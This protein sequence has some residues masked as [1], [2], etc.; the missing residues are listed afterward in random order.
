MRFATQSEVSSLANVEAAVTPGRLAAGIEPYLPQATTEQKG[1]VELATGDEV[2]S[3]TDSTKAVT[4]A[5]LS[6]AT[7]A[8][9]NPIGTIIAF[10][11]ASA[12][13]GYLKCNGDVIN[14]VP[15]QTIQGVTADF[16]N[17]R[18]VLGT[19]YN[20]TQSGDVVLPDLRGEFLRGW[21]DDRI[22][23]DSGR[24]MGST[25]GQTVQS[26]AHSG[27]AGPADVDNAGARYGGGNRTGETGVYSTNATGDTETR[28]RNVAILY[29]IKF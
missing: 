10:A 5:T 8:A 7:S 20:P 14:D 25:Q 9:G 13:T 2:V 1:V 3:G 6:L 12:P 4:P 28:P 26:H 29:C 23:V 11:G 19:T 22:G 17:L 24:A 16:R 27:P 21:S 18:T 15:A